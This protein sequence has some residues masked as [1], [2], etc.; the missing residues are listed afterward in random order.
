MLHKNSAILHV[1]RQLLK[2]SKLYYYNINMDSYEDDMLSELSKAEQE[3]AKEY[4]TTRHKKLYVIRHI[5][6]KELLM[7]YGTELY[8]DK[9]GKAKLKD[10]EIEFSI[11]YSNDYFVVAIADNHMVGADIEYIMPLDNYKNMAEIFLT[12][13]EVEIFHK[14]SPAK[15]LKLFYYFWTAKE[16]FIKSIGQGM[17]FDLQHVEFKLNNNQ[18]L[19]VKSIINSYVAPEN[20]LVEQLVIDNDVISIVT[21]DMP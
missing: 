6:L 16:A 13:N 21:S 18:K 9:L 7:P 17:E 14:A 1:H 10:S 2:R 3:K 11:S 12:E 4:T 19:T 20:T 15:Q 8:Y 5:L